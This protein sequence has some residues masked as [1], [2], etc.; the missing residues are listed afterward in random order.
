[1][2]LTLK[3]KGTIAG[4]NAFGAKIKAPYFQWIALISG[5]QSSVFEEQRDVNRKNALQNMQNAR[6]RRE[7]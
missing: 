7:Q 2:M 1:M 5:K 3:G 6:P 4:T